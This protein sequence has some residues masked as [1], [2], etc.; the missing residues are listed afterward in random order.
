MSTGSHSFTRLLC[1]KLLV[2][3][4]VGGYVAEWVVSVL[5]SGAERS[6]SNRS[7]DVVR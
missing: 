1:Y 5:D 2:W 7:R 6:G 3:Y 4:L